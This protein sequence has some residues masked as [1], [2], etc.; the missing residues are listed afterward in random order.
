MQRR[1]RYIVAMAVL[2]FLGHTSAAFAQTKDLSLSLGLKLWYHKW[3]S[4]TFSATTGYNGRGKSNK[5]MG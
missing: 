2:I 4:G 3:D 1:Y 5:L